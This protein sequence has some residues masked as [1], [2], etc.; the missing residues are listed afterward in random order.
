MDNCSIDM[1]HLNKDYYCYLSVAFLNALS[2][3]II[4][5]TVCLVVNPV[6][7]DSYALLFY[8]TEA[9]RALDSMTASS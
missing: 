7:A 1:Y 9:V 2:I 5:Q 3:D 8:C 6:T 4:L